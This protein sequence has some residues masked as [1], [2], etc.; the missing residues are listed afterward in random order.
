MKRYKKFEDW[1]E[2][3][4]YVSPRCFRFWEELQDY[5]NPE[6]GVRLVS[7]APIEKWLRAAFE[8]GQNVSTRD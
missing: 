8:A 3:T 4:E 5:L 2:E 6:K 1:F 7:A